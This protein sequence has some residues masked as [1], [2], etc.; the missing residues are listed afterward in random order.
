MVCCLVI[1]AT[2]EPGC[3]VKVIGTVKN[4]YRWSCDV[5]CRVDVTVQRCDRWRRTV[6]APRRR[7]QV[8]QRASTPTPT[9]LGSDI[10][11]CCYASIPLG[12]R[13]SLMLLRFNIPLAHPP[14]SPSSSS[15]SSA[16]ATNTFLLLLLNLLLLTWTLRRRPRPHPHRRCRPPPPPP[17]RAP[18]SCWRPPRSR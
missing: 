9:A 7:P 6:V 8:S 11:S 1:T 5:P 10:L 15:S 4:K 13:C 3:G 17:R 14:P 18:P 12:L 16:A 2:S